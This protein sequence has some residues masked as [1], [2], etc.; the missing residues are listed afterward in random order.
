M[1]RS[2]GSASAWHKSSHSGPHGGDCVEVTRWRK[3]S[4]SGS[5]GGD[6]IE[7]GRWRKSSSS[8][9]E[10]GDCV[11]VSAWR[12]NSHSGPD[13]GQ[14]VEVASFA[15]AVAVRDSKDPNGPKLVFGAIAWA[16]FSARVKD[17]E[18]DPA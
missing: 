13:G 4:V 5:G 7:V 8:G 9:P 6:C 11:E 10:G 17:C 2:A 1:P 14:C 12:K 3:S 15:P 18:L 16:V